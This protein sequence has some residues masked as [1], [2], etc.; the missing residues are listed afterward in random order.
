MEIKNCWKTK[1]YWLKGGVLGAV[2]VL[3]YYSLFTAILSSLFSSQAELLSAPFALPFIL[4]ST[5]F[6]GVYLEAIG[7]VILFTL[8]FLVGALTGWAIGKI[9]K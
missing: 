8:Y 6:S 5:W 4:S 2:F 3:V 7:F 1:P 9:K